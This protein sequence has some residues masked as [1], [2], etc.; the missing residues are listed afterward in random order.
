MM[1]TPRRL[2]RVLLRV[3][4]PVLVA[5]LLSP[6]AV[7][8]AEPAPAKPAAIELFPDLPV[9]KGKGF[10]IKA[11]E[12]ER[13]FMEY[14]ANQAARGQATIPEAQRRDIEDKLLAR[15]I[16]TRILVS[17]AGPDD[18]AKGEIA[19]NKAYADLRQRAG[20]EE[21]FKR[22]VESMGMTTESLKSQLIERGVSEEVF[23][24]EV[25]NKIAIPEA[26]MAKFYTDNPARFEQPEKVRISLILKLTVDPTLLRVPNAKLE[27]PEEKKKASRAEIEKLLARAQMGEDFAKLV[28][29]GSDDPDKKAN[30]GEYTFP[31]GAM[32]P[33]FELACFALKP[34]EISGIVVT[35]LGYQI[36]KLHEKI[37]AKKTEYELVK[38]RIREQLQQQ[39]AEKQMPGYFEKLKAEAEVKILRAVPAP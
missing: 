38:A 9:V 30:N 2:L 12:L 8:A 13:A 6:V 19:G 11:S 10:E 4:A 5:V 1:P 14:R 26:D 23:S 32:S 28:V 37:P 39:E 3:P 29:E 18:K 22:Q 33:E 17:K 35:K 25:K 34:N 24:R 20:T 21:S 36:I 27:L 31:R 16:V 7:T 15:M